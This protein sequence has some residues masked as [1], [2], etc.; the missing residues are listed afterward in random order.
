[1]FDVEK[2]IEVLLKGG[3]LLYPTDTVW[4]LGCDAANIDA[5]RRIYRIKQRQES[6]SLI[7][8]VCDF[9][10]LGKYVVLQRSVLEFLST[11]EK[12][13]SVIYDKVLSVPDFLLS[14]DGTIAI[15]VASDPYCKEL[16]RGFGG[17]IVST[18]ANVSGEPTPA[19]FDEISPQIKAQVDFISPY[20]R[21]DK[22]PRESSSIVR[23]ENG[24]IV[25][26]RK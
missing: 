6:K 8:L 3:V 2:E 26:I 23:I 12:P 18:S 15:R 19:F 13:T 22:T 24:K 1:M 4:G 11:R 20:F 17:A 14:C 5:V 21:D 7:L 9:D 10:M 16:I 25:Y